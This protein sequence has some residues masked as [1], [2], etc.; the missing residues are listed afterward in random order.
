MADIEKK[1]EERKIGL[2]INPLAGKG[3][4]TTLAL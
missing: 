4:S 2:F 3:R 1:T